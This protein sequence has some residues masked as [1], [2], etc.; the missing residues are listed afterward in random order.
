MTMDVSCSFLYAAVARDLY[1]E[2]PAGDPEGGAGRV[3]HLR[4]ALYG[5]RDAPALW[6]KTLANVMHKLGFRESVVQPGFFIHQQKE[7]HVVTHVDDFLCARPVEDL[8]WFKQA[9]SENFDISE[10]QDEGE[11]PE[12]PGPKDLE[13]GEWLRLGGGPE[14]RPD[15]PGGAGADGLQACGLS[16][17][18]EQ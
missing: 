11:D 17:G 3:G 8:K 6:Q 14:A 18:E 2:L 7:V 15:P 5:T 1:I 13:G 10:E 4:K 12:V 9:L 16:H